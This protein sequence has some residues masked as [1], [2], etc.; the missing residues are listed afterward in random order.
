M[1]EVYGPQD[2]FFIVLLLSALLGYSQAKLCALLTPNSQTA[3]VYYA[4]LI[5]LEMVLSGFL[6]FPDNAPDYLK[7]TMDL[8]FTRWAVYGLLFN[9]FHNFKENGNLFEGILNNQGDL[10]LQFYGLSSYDI[11]RC[12]WILTIFFAVMEFMV[13]IAML[14]PRNLL[15]KLDSL[16]EA[17][18]QC[19]GEAADQAISEISQSL[20]I[21]LIST[22]RGDTFS[23]KSFVDRFSIPTVLS[24][25]TPSLIEPYD[26][27]T[28]SSNRIQPQLLAPDG[29]ILNRRTYTEPRDSCRVS[30]ILEPQSRGQLL[31]RDVTYSIQKNGESVRLL[32]GISGLVSS[33]ELCAIMGS[34][35][36][37][38]YLFICFPIYFHR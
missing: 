9:Q 36:A 3:F 12:I 16:P 13:I 29:R 4:L 11:T 10:V 22:S 23:S 7:W 38:L 15:S 20:Q 21:D 25:F 27:L 28:T 14:P 37:G 5:S 35:G 8:M 1:S 34:S 26:K 33:G 2:I 19:H 32:Q 18:I 31:F 6:I 24:Q 17:S 30:D